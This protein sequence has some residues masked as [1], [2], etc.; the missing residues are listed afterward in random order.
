MIVADTGFFIALLNSRDSFHANAQQAITNLQEP[1]ITTHPVLT[2]TCYL[3]FRSVGYE[4]Q[5]NFLKS[6]SRGAFDVFNIERH[7]VARIIELMKQYADLPMDFA[8]ASLVVL[9]EHLGHGRILTCDRRD[10]STYR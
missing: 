6:F 8:D 9:A 7:H 4:A 10:F 5:V 2:E 3:L 1:L